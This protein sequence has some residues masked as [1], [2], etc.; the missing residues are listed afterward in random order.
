M[1][2]RKFLSVVA[3]VMASWPGVARAQQAER[4]RHV[5]VLMNLPADAPEAQAQMAA[6]VQG[7]QGAGWEVGSVPSMLNPCRF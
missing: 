7:L 5:G 1:R 6:F 2:R 4:M 3:G